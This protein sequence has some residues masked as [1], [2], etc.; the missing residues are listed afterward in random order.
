MFQN[1]EKVETKLEIIGSTKLEVHSEPWQRSK[2][3]RFVRIIK[4]F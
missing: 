2:M 1:T 3:E 4:D